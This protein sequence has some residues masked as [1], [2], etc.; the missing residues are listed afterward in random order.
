MRVIVHECV[1]ISIDMYMANINSAMQC[2]AGGGV[3]RLLMNGMLKQHNARLRKPNQRTYTTT[4]GIATQGSTFNTNSMNASGHHSELEQR[5][6][7]R[8]D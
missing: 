3:Q 6:S 8:S 5:N 7:K 2:N 1:C 4:Q